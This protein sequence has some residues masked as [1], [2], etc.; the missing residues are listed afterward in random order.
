MGKNGFDFVKIDKAVI[1]E[2]KYIAAFVLI[3]SVLMQAVFLILHAYQITTWDYKVI[4]GN[5][6]GAG[7]AIGNFFVMGL[8]VQKAV[9]QEAQDAKKTL[10]LSQSVRFAAIVVLAA[11]GLLIPIFNRIT[12]V[13]PLLF[14]SVAIFMRPLFKKKK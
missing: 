10:K 11:V 7:I 14:P 12:V 13:I 9:S 6:W 4:L 3:F 1:K 8:Y 2:T 5:V